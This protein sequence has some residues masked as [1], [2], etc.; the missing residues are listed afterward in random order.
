MRFCRLIYEVVWSAC[1]KPGQKE[2]AEGVGSGWWLWRGVKSAASQPAVTTQSRTARIRHVVRS[3]LYGMEMEMGMGMGDAK[4]VSLGQSPIS[5]CALLLPV[6]FFGKR[7]INVASINKQTD[8][9]RKNIY[10]CM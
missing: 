7:F 5:P 1:S 3:H 8:A 2:D 10:V 6:A 9:G 4:D